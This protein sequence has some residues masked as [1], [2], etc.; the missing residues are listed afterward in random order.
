MKWAVFAMWQRE[1]TDAAQEFRQ[2]IEILSPAGEQIL[3]SV[4]T[5]S[6]SPTARTHRN[7]LNMGV[8]P[9]GIAG[10]VRTI[11]VS[12]DGELRGEY[13]L[14]LKINVSPAASRAH[15]NRRRLKTNPFREHIG[16]S[17]V[18]LVYCCQDFA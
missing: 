12:L 15:T 16:R 3:N 7:V 5:F 10:A 9:V 8:F 14:E 11:R 17:V 18:S 6:F 4:A 2:A 1:A 13:K